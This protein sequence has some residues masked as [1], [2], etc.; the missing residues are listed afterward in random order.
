MEDY[1]D[2]LRVNSAAQWDRNS[3]EALF[4][5]KLGAREWV[6]YEAFCEFFDTRPAEVVA[7]ILM[8]WSGGCRKAFRGVEDFSCRRRA[9]RVAVPLPVC[10]HV[11]HESPSLPLL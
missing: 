3:E 10:D 8:Y 9:A 4:V 5:R 6:D 2:Y 1:R 7:N 11:P